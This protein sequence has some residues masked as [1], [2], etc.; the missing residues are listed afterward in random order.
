MNFTLKSNMDRFI[1]FKKIKLQFC[2][3]T[4][5]SNMDRFIAKLACLAFCSFFTLKSNMDRFIDPEWHIDCI[6]L[7]YFKIQYG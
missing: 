7:N 3:Q 4:L 2:N 1:D 6:E 5:K